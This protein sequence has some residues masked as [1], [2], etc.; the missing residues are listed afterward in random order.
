LTPAIALNPYSGI[1]IIPF[2]GAPSSQKDVLTLQNEMAELV[3]EVITELQKNNTLKDAQRKAHDFL[4]LT[5]EVYHRDT[6]QDV[7]SNAMQEL[8]NKPAISKTP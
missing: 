4:R 1:K 8:F 7:S 2:D 5:K 6:T 3:N